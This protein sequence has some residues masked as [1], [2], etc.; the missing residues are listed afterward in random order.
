MATIFTSYVPYIRKLSAKPLKFDEYVV[1]FSNNIHYPTLSLGFTH[2][3]HKSLDN[4]AIFTRRF[5]NSR[6]VYLITQPFETQ[7]EF[8]ETQT[9]NSGVASLTDVSPTSINNEFRDYLQKKGYNEPIIASGFMKM[10]EINTYFNVV[11]EK[12]N[13]QTIYSYGK[14]S[15]GSMLQC[16]EFLRKN[17]KDTV[18]DGQNKPTKNSA[19]LIICDTEIDTSNVYTQ[20]Q[21]MFGQLISNI[22]EGLN[23]QKKDGTFILKISECYTP[24]TIKLI[25]YVKQFYKHAWICKPLVCNGFSTER[26][27]VFK[28]FKLAK[29][30]KEDDNGLKHMVTQ[31]QENELFNIYD[32]FA[33]TD[34]NESCH[35]EYV[36][37]NS[38]FGFMQYVAINK[39]LIY[40]QGNNY[41]GADYN[42]YYNKQISAARFYKGI[43]LD[44]KVANR[45]GKELDEICEIG[46]KVE[47]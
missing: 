9:P 1:D 5:E 39:I 20:E 38:D 13:S 31:V 11:D 18:H 6:K 30:E 46:L 47:E 19:D 14:N 4:F 23:Y 28:E 45:V 36:K 22:Q 29:L 2:F 12:A 3:Y 7:I 26:Y 44:E 34:L 10:W 33:S 32:V 37:L 41:N 8:T 17:K 16:V 21:N 40:I 24:V 25:E 27:L 15:D 42:E 43:F 35:E